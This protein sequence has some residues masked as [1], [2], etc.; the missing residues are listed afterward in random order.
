M[1]SPVGI[2]VGVIVGEE[3]RAVVLEPERSVCRMGFRSRR[4]TFRLERDYRRDRR[5]LLAK[6]HM[7]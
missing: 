5:D 2:V 6:S 3:G 4:E 7:L 1:Q